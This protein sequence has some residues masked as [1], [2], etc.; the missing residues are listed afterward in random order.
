MWRG[1]FLPDRGSH[2]IIYIKIIQMDVGGIF[3]MDKGSLG[4]IYIKII[5]MAVGGYSSWIRIAM[6]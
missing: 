4:I 3:L 1:I 5:Q 6:G 2:G